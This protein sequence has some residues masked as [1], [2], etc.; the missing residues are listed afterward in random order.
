MGCQ[1]IQLIRISSESQSARTTQT[2]A[3]KTIQTEDSAALDKAKFQ[4]PF[5]SAL[6][7]EN[8]YF[9]PAVT[10]QPSFDWDGIQR[11]LQLRCISDRFDLKA[12]IS[13]QTEV[14]DCAKKIEAVESMRKQIQEKSGSGLITED[15]RSQGR[16]LRSDLKQLK[17]KMRKILP[18]FQKQALLL[19]NTLHPL[20]PTGP[21]T[22]VVRP[23][24]IGASKKKISW[25]EVAD[26]IYEAPVGVYFTGKL[27]S[28]EKDHVDYARDYWFGLEDD[29]VPTYPINLSDFARGPAVEGTACPLLHEAIRL[30]PTRGDLFQVEQDGESNPKWLVNPNTSCYLVGSAS[31]ASFIAYLVR[32]KLVCTT[33][34]PFR[35]VTSGSCYTGTQDDG[36]TFKYRTGTDSSNKPPFEQRKQV[37]LLEL[38]SSWA[39]CETGFERVVS[40]LCNFWSHYQPS[41]SLRHVRVPAPQ[42]L[43]CEMLRSVIDAK[44]PDC[45]NGPSSLSLASVSLLHEW[46]SRRVSVRIKSDEAD[47]TQAFYPHMVYARLMDFRSLMT[48]FKRTGHLEEVPK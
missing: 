19:P 25:S 39:E 37:S 11:S 28:L 7:R 4:L 38:S 43:P 18:T 22:A 48:A 5:G 32:Q 16:A 3:T 27:A 14:E 30:E 17:E 44:L 33:P 21:D 15:I 41:W 20:C 13:L 6:F 12:L 29:G 42:L 40:Q 36:S 46:I 34:T 8:V 47:G 23:L 2:S 45:P 1:G 24:G 35:L 10:A 31:L 26:D 9:S